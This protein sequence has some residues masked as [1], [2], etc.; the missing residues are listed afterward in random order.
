LRLTGSPVGDVGAA[1]LHSG[2]FQ[3][4][5]EERRREGTGVPRSEH[6]PSDAPGVRDVGAAELRAQ[7]GEQ[8][9]GERVGLDR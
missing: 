7:A 3:H 9:C 1:E 2:F 8:A 5:V 4:V 6:S